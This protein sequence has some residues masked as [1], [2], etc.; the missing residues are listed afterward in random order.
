MRPN[1]PIPRSACLAVLAS[2]VGLT[3][4]AGDASAASPVTNGAIVA[5]KCE[6][7]PPCPPAHLWLIDPLTGAEHAL[8]TN[9]DADDTPAFSPDGSRVVFRRCPSGG[10]TC[11]I[12]VI[13]ADGS[14]QHD[15]TDGSVA[16]DDYPSYSADG[17]RIAFTRGGQIYTMA[18]DGTDAK[19]LGVL[20][21][22]APRFSPDGASILYSHYESGKGY[23]IFTM[24]SGGGA[25]VALTLGPKDLDPSWSPDGSHIV[26]A[27]SNGNQAIWVMDA[28]GANQ[29][30]LTPFSLSANDQEPVYSPD[31]SQIAFERTSAASNGPSPLIVMNADGGNVHPVTL[32]SEYFYK[33]DW[34]PLH[35]SPPAPAADTTPPVVHLSVPR[36]ESIGKGRIYLFA[37]SNE[38]AT[39]VARG[40]VA[41]P[42]ASKRFAVKRASKALAPNTRTKIQVKLGKRSLRAIRSA[43]AHHRKV[44]ARIVL[45]VTDGAGNV[46]RGT[47]TIRLKS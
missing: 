1:F 27:R 24:P 2:A 34:Q 22:S 35:P 9:A 38:T 26:F 44:K 47:L 32:A 18:A 25:P 4:T 33:A 42:V 28:N 14:G 15:L 8:T 13:N 30:A 36:K 7:G 16:E 17:T 45:N 37:T 43:L 12:A 31:G 6:A 21:S 41:V 5:T 23:R 19:P 29:H 46:T 39:A 3:L 10:A 20:S 40:G 11:R